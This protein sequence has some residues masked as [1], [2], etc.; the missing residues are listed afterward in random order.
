MSA[1]AA[2][3]WLER[4]N[5]RT[6][7]DCGVRLAAASHAV[8]PS[9]KNLQV[10]IEDQIKSDL[11]DFAFHARKLMERRSLKS[12]TV[13]SDPLWPPSQLEP[14]EKNLWALLGLI[15]HADSIDVSWEQA[16]L[17]PNP[18]KGRSPMFAGSVKVQSDNGSATLP[19]GSLTSTFFGQVLASS[20]FQEE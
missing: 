1:I 14:P 8:W 19:I 5:G 15:V 20:D 18:Y 2:N 7:Q 12:A 13:G 10:L 16:D 3:D 4:H 11:L 17:Q 9:D 6:A